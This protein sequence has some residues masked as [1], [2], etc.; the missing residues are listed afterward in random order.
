MNDDQL[1]ALVA[2]V[3]HGTFDAA[4][5]ALSVTPSAVSQRIRALESSTGRVLVVRS[6]PCRTTDAGTTVLRLAR[7][8]L[9]LTSEALAELSA[10]A[11]TVME[12]P[13]AVNADSLVTWF[14]PVLAECAQWG[15][16]VLHLHV[17]DQDHSAELLRSGTVLGAV[18]SD[19]VA[20]Q[21]CSV[22]KL[23]TIRYVPV[24]NPDLAARWTTGRGVS[25]G[26]MP[27]VQFNAKDDLQHRVLAAH[28]VTASP[29]THRVPTSDGFLHAVHAGLGWGAVPENQ[30][31]DD[32]QTGRLVLLS[33]HDHVEVPLFWQC[34]RLRSPRVKRITELVR[35][36]ATALH[37]PAR[38]E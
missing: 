2:V 9:L 18:T 19:P 34:W 16:I 7:Q 8:R 14:E 17:E 36:A 37:A 10:H 24:A 21:G 20:V 30:L 13:V 32:L 4:A 12:L 29:P 38:L 33:P 5:R 28:H 6:S 3:D 1:A 25:W 31:G 23:G 35:A 27:M 22:E 26:S 11:G 15:E